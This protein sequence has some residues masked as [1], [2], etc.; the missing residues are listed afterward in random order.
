MEAPFNSRAMRAFTATEAH[1]TD[2]TFKNGDFYGEVTPVLGVRKLDG[3]LSGCR[4]RIDVRVR[5]DHTVNFFPAN[6]QTFLL[7]LAFN[8]HVKLTTCLVLQTFSRAKNVLRSSTKQ[9]LYTFDT[10]WTV[11]LNEWTDSLADAE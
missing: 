4:Y 2:V 7:K 1:M 6:S 5:S 3:S 8:F 10:R 11:L 9:R